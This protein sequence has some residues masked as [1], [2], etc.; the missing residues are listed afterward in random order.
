MY[1]KV[2]EQYLDLECIE[3]YCEGFM[4]LFDILLEI[5]NALAIGVSTDSVKLLAQ[6]S[7]GIKREDKHVISFLDDFPTPK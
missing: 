6:S 1:I 2:S 5:K 4:E 7:Q 3:I